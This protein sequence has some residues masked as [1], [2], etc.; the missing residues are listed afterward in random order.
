MDH[1]DSYFD[2]VPHHLPP[3]LAMHPIHADAQKDEVAGVVPPS[4][5]GF[6]SCAPIS[7]FH[8]RHP[9]LNHPTFTC[10]P[11]NKSVMNGSHTNGIGSVGYADATHDNGGCSFLVF[12]LLHKLRL[13][14]VP[15]PDIDAPSPLP[16]E[17]QM[18]RVPL[19]L[20]DRE[21]SE[22]VWYCLLS[23]LRATRMMTGGEC[24]SVLMKVLSCLRCQGHN[25]IFAVAVGIESPCGTLGAYHP[26]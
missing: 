14:A 11:T 19:Q 1:M 20:Q 12:D 25:I 4:S 13:H 7:L 21:R 2:R 3:S 17:W 24:C 5:L 8:A 23:L 26:C 22:W 6:V 16:W 15:S 18:S 9:H 10:P